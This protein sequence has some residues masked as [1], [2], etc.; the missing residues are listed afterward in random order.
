[1][2]PD[3]AAVLT[4]SDLAARGERRDESGDWLVGRLSDAFLVVDRV[5]VPDEVDLIRARLAAWVARGVRL[6]V[7]TGGTGLGPRDVTPE[8][9]RLVATREVP[10]MAEAM[11]ARSAPGDARTMLSRQVVAAAG[12]TLI[13]TLPG[14]PRG[15]RE[16]LEVVWPV[17]P[18]ALHLLA[19]RTA[20]V[21]ESDS[22]R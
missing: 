9:V 11:R 4:A 20:H 15:A 22:G 18:H 21:P 10:G 19:G 5:V 3:T 14:S 7:T 8:A 13:V 16:C 2:M 17:L 12:A 6:V 1:M